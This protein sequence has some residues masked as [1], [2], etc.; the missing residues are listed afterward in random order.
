M[1]AHQTNYIIYTNEYI[2]YKS[3]Y[4]CSY[5]EHRNKLHLHHQPTKFF[6]TWKMKHWNYLL[7]QMHCLVLVSNN[8][9]SFR[10]WRVEQRWE[11]LNC[12]ERARSMWSMV[13]RE[14]LGA[15]FCHIFLKETCH[16]QKTIFSLKQDLSAEKSLWNHYS[17]FWIC[18]DSNHV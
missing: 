12:W 6:K 15:G 8:R 9:S 5:V 11:L 1:T 16:D 2:S 18:S 4:T 3:Y 10:V 7:Q 13:T 14:E 17:T